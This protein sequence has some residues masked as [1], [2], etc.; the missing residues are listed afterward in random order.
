[1]QVFFFDEIKKIIQSPACFI[2][3]TQKKFKNTPISGMMRK[4]SVL[5]D[6][7]GKHF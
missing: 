7:S 4:K 3:P 6:D 2:I 5:K 1:M